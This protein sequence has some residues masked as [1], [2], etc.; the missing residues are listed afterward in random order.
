MIQ[1]T[2]FVNYP[3]KKNSNIIILKLT[4]GNFKYKL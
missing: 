1:L 3:E 4:I 2:L